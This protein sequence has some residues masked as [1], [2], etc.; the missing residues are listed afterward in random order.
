[1]PI[2]NADSNST[3][4]DNPQLNQMVA[5]VN[6]LKHQTRRKKMELR[7]RAISSIEGCITVD[8]RKLSVRG[9]KI[10][11]NNLEFGDATTPRDTPKRSCPLSVGESG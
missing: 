8:P 2:E 5:V 4:Q 9:T 1:M 3:N 6:E 7:H 10:N 11:S